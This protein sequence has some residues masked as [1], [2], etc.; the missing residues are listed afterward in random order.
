MIRTIARARERINQALEA[1]RNDAARHDRRYKTYAFGNHACNVE[2]HEAWA[3]DPGA[4]HTPLGIYAAN[5]NAQSTIKGCA[6][7]TR[8]ARLM[9]RLERV[10]EKLGATVVWSDMVATCDSCE[11]LLE[12]EPDSWGWQPNY[13]ENNDGITCLACHAEAA[14]ETADDEA[15]A[16]AERLAD[17]AE[18][19]ADAEQ[20]ASDARDD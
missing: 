13:V 16:E 20:A 2:C 11:L 18:A 7:T 5:W 8:A 17:E 14:K 19:K 4:V 10:L 3:G 1:A 12:T 9:P 15:E 6:S